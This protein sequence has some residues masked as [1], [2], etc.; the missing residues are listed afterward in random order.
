M[1]KFWRTQILGPI[2]NGKNE[3]KWFRDSL[4]L[5][6]LNSLPFSPH[7]SVSWWTAVKDK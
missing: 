3:A 2:P 6:G 4:N 7:I 5:E 1:A